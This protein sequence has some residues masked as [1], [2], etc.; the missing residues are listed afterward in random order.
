M[1]QPDSLSLT[2]LA[3]QKLDR[4]QGALRVYEAGRPGKVY[5]LTAKAFVD[6]VAYNGAPHA[7]ALRTSMDASKALAAWRKGA[8]SE[9]HPK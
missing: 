9:S 2:R 7:A 6:A 3:L 1:A 8:V 5:S 4:C